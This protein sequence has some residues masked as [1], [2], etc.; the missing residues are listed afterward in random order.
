ML[1]RVSMLVALGLLGWSVAEAQVVRSG[2]SGLV[3]M[4]RP[5]GRAPIY[6]AGSAPAASGIRVAGPARRTAGRMPGNVV[7]PGTPGR[8]GGGSVTSPGIPGGTPGRVGNVATPGSAAARRPVKRTPRTP[9]P[10]RITPAPERRNIPLHYG[11]GSQGVIAV[12]YPVLY[13]VYDEGTNV[14]APEGYAATASEVEFGPL[15]ER[16]EEPEEALEDTDEPEH[17]PVAE[18]KILEIPE[19]DAPRP[20]YD[21]DADFHLIAFK[22]GN[23]YA[24]TNHWLEDETLHYV[25][26]DGHHNLV[27]LAEVDLDFTAR[28]NNE[29]GLVF[30]MEVRQ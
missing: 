12:P 4:R 22:N 26:R 9:A 6:G 13:P 20:V 3:T 29:R 28:L 2:T 17:D 25:T 1:A 27:T 7:A 18:S 14:A 8:V 21:R 5:S 11:Y 23:I 15:V 16:D 19:D 30:A 10:A 24:A